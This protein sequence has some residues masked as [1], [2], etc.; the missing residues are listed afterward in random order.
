[1]GL[2]I[3]QILTPSTQAQVRANIV[4]T[5]QSLNIP[6]DK[7]VAGGVASSIIT[8]AAAV[9]SSLSTQLSNGVTAY[10]LPQASGGILALVAQYVYGVT[11]PTAT[12]AKGNYTLTNSGG[13]P[14]TVLQNQFICQSTVI[15][16]GQTAGMTYTNA[17]G[18]FTVP[19]SGSVTFVVE[20]TQAGSIGNASPGDITKL[21]TPL[22][23]V[24]GTNP[25]ALQA[26]DAP[27]DASIRTLCTNAL[28]VRSVRGPR[29][30]YAY[31]IQTALNAVSGNPVNINRWSI[32]P[33]SHTGIETIVVAS[34]S[35]TTDPNDI[36]GVISNIEAVARPD[37]VQVFVSAASLSNYT[38]TISSYVQVPPGV[39]ATS[40]QTAMQ[41]AVATLFAN[42]PVGGRTIIDDSGTI[43]G[44][45]A[46]AV[47]GAMAQGVA[48]IPGCV[49]LSA[50]GGIDLA[51]ASTSVA[52]NAVTILPP[53][54]TS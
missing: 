34:P 32:S 4:S 42:Y 22:T 54:V 29:T 33:S 27:S 14:Y 11:P 43:T 10:F 53:T 49:F 25:T 9:L 28:G 23:N 48:T 3:Q 6:A 51:L 26:N 24:T 41:T 45:T 35:G 18:G 47:Y 21:V 44:I 40:V 16:I 1:M 8:A 38:A 31:A 36:L 46:D 52:V 2:T 17:F 50:K 12:F 7:W 5:L 39:S 19:A 15:P 37:A 13:V 20:A 30:A